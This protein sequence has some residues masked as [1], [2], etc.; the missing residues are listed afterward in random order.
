MLRINYVFLAP[1]IVLSLPPSA[2]GQQSI[3]VTAAVAIVGL[4]G[5]SLGNRAAIYA[6]SGSLLLLI[7]WGKVAGDL[8]GFPGPDSA[9]LLLQFMLVIFLMEASIT[10]LTLD[11]AIKPLEGKNDDLSESARMRAMRWERVQFFNLGKLTAASFV[12]SLGLLILGSLV[13]V[14]FNEIAFSGVLV[15]A[16]VVAIFVLLTYRREPEERR[17]SVE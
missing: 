8:Y 16:A 15:L 2:L 13:S 4:A 7:V 14:S 5:M 11:S 10:V 6:A 17:R 3:L 9:V 1:W 12:L